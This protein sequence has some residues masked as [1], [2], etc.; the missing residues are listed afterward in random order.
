MRNRNIRDDLMAQRRLCGGE[1]I[2]S[3]GPEM[4]HNAFF[5][6]ILQ[7]LLS[8]T[9]AVPN[10][11]LLG[12]LMNR[13]A[14]R[15]TVFNALKELVGQ[16]PYDDRQF[17]HF[18]QDFFPGPRPNSRRGSNGTN[19]SGGS[20]GS[21][22]WRNRQTIHQIV[23]DMVDEHGRPVCMGP[24]PTDP[25][26]Q[27]PVVQDQPLFGD[28]QQQPVA[29]EQQPQDEMTFSEARRRMPYADFEPGQQLYEPIARR[30]RARIVSE[31]VEQQPQPQMQEERSSISSTRLQ[32]GQ[33]R[34]F[35]LATET[36]PYDQVEQF[37]NEVVAAIRLRN[38][39]R[40][41][42]DEEEMT[43][44]YPNAALDAL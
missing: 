39:N 21:G 2:P 37:V 12:Y 32:R 10:A 6:V 17:R 27:Q 23:T 14:F 4:A 24:R 5:R 44:G 28:E 25:L 29:Q 16:V 22:G 1:P 40:Q 19:Q 7:K 38:Q 11:Y 36:G 35:V 42:N 13:G 34:D 26:Q 43:A 3:D 20:N 8:S 41:P 15:S 31:A 30:T 18:P 33:L 9:T